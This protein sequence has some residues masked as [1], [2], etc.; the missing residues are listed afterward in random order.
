MRSV[1][2]AVPVVRLAVRL[3]APVVRRAVRRVVPVARLAAPVV[4]LRVVVRRV[5]RAGRSR[6]KRSAIVTSLA[7]DDFAPIGVKDL[8]CHVG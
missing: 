7:V 4:R 5:C 1:R 3:A 2:R 8:A 6:P